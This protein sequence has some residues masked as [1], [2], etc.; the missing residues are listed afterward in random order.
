MAL[1]EMRYVH[2]IAIVL[3]CK[4]NTKTYDEIFNQD[5][6]LHNFK[7]KLDEVRTKLA[8]EAEDKEKAAKE[9]VV[10]PLLEEKPAEESKKPAEENEAGFPYK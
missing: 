10:Q 7:Q 8:K 3:N 1:D 9:G 5:L 2:T 4:Q 6:G